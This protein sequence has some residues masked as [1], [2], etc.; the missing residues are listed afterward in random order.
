[1]FTLLS[2]TLEYDSE[3]HENPNQKNA[4]ISKPDKTEFV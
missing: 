2:K 3:T 4:T 1:M